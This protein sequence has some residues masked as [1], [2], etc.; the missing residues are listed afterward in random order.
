M[1]AKLIVIFI[2]FIIFSG[3]ISVEASS[4]DYKVGSNLSRINPL[5]DFSKPSNPINK[6]VEDVLAHAPMAFTEN[7][8]QLENDEVRFYVQGGEI[9][10]TD[11]GMWIE[12]KDE[13]SI[14]SQQSTVDSHGLG[15]ILNSDHEEYVHHEIL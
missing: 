1:R 4:G 14:N 11:D 2:T 12:V 3:Y 13:L 10:F 5:L 15:S 7:Q 8:G 9:W 6:D